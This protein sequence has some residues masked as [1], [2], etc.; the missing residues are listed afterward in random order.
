MKN[1]SGNLEFH[2]EHIY[3]PQSEQDII[4]TIELARTHKKSL[5]PIGSGH[6]WTALYNTDEYLL[7]LKEY[8]GM[9]N[10]DVKNHRMCFKAGTKMSRVTDI[11]LEHKLSLENQGDINAQAIA[12]ALST[13]THGT[14]EKLRSMANQ[15][16]QFKLLTAAGEVKQIDKD[17]TPELYQAA[18]VSMGMLGII[19]EIEVQALPLYQLEAETQAVHFSDVLPQ[20]DQLVRDNRHFELFYF[21]IGDWALMKRTNITDKLP[22]QKTLFNRA[23]QYLNDVILENA[24]FGLAN[25]L[26]HKSNRYHAVDKLMRK[27][28]SKTSKVDFAQNVFPTQR[29]VKFMEMEYNV[30]RNDFNRVL[31]EIQSLIKSSNML[32]LFPI[33][34]R[35][36]ASD[37]LWLSPA[38]QRESVYFAIHT[39]IEEEYLE[40]F[41]AMESIFKRYQGR[42]HWGKWHSLKSEDLQK[43][44]PRYNDFLTLRRELDPKEVFIHAKNSIF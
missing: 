19:S 32:T 27:F 7:D 34:I 2:P 15:M 9:T 31:S 5:R 18:A 25:Q 21:P 11:L 39:Y 24:L 10:V 4:Q 35:F 29:S 40:Y 36:V 38:Y 26:A 20:I 37:N 12:G 6:S 14:G 22:P 3:N 8:S 13:G 17:K 41:K 1:W 42:P 44:Y 23:G 30:D 28:V 43:V 33:E 16:Q